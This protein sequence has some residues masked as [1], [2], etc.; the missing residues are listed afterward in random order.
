MPPFESAPQ[1]GKWSP[2]EIQPLPK[3]AVLGSSSE[4]APGVDLNTVGLVPK[5]ETENLITAA[6]QKKTEDKVKDLK[7]KLASGVAQGMTHPEKAAIRE[8]INASQKAIHLAEERSRLPRWIRKAI[9]WG[10]R[11]RR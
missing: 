10:D 3:G 6:D 11:P 8:E 5:T 7:A 1:K 2:Q 9:G 4:Y